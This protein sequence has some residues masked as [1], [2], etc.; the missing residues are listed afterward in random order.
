MTT[1]RVNKLIR[2]TQELPMLRRGRGDVGEARLGVSPSSSR[3]AADRLPLGFS[4]CRRHGL[5]VYSDTTF[6]I[7]MG[8]S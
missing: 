3:S 4:H 5:Y 1:A 8:R 2:L 6:R 7:F